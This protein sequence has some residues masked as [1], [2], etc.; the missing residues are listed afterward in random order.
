MRSCL[1]IVVAAALLLAADEPK[2]GTKDSPPPPG[3]SFATEGSGIP[4]NQD[5]TDYAIR[6]AEINLQ[7]KSDLGRSQYLG[8]SCAGAGPRPTSSSRGPPESGS[9]SSRPARSGWACPMRTPTTITSPSTRCGS[10][11]SIW[12]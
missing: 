3:R 2:Q 10:A 7:S 1:P 4:S 6:V 9:R 12:A 11:H 8:W 5:A